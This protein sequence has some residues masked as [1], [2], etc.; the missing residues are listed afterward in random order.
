MAAPAKLITTSIGFQDPKG[1]VVASGMLKL[2]LSQTATVTATGGQVTTEPIFLNLDANGKITNTAIWFNDELSPS[3]TIYYGTVYAANKTRVIPGLETL[4]YSITGAGPYD[5]ATA[6]Q[7]ASASPSYSGA[8][9]LVPSGSQT[10]TTGNLT[11]TTGT[12]VETAQAVT[13]SGGLV[14]A[15]S[16]TLVTPNIGVATGTSLALGGGTA[17]ATTNRTGTGNLVLATNPA[18]TGPTIDNITQKAATLFSLFDNQ[19][20]TRLSI[21]SGGSAQG[22]INNMA[23]TGVNTF[24]NVAVLNGQGA[25]GPLTGNSADQVIYTYTLPANTVDSTLKGIRITAAAVHASGT[26]NTTLKININSVNAVSGVSGT[27]A[28]QSTSFEARILRTASTTGGSWGIANAAAS[29][30]TPFSQAL[31]GLAWTS[32]QVITFTFNVANTDTWTGIM[33]LVELIQ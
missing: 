15:T 27:A 25:V 28:S 26:A 32:S 20:G 33:F 24:N 7:S 5:L 1:T 3:G 6:V 14:R 30:M 31:T 23:L 12:F 13:G 18:I 4:Q 2:T 10:I 22:Q 16:P 17:L 19:A 11:L 8:V 29:S 21:P 9:L